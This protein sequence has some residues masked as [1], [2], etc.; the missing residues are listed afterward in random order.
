MARALLAALVVLMGAL[1]FRIHVPVVSL[2][3]EM[4]STTGARGEIFFASSEVG[5]TQDRSEPF[6]IHSDGE[7]HAYEVA[8]SPG[9]R[10]DRIRIDP[11]SGP[12]SVSVRAV[13]LSQGIHS[14]R[15]ERQRLVGAL[16]I[17]KH[18]QPLDPAALRFSSQGGDPYF[19]ILLP[20][21]MG[22]SSLLARAGELVAV[23]AIALATWILLEVLAAW[24]AKRIPPLGRIRPAVARVSDLL[25]DEQVLRVDG[26]IL[27]AFL[28]I[29]LLAAIYV[30]LRLHQSSIGIWETIHPHE[31]VEQTIDLGTPKRIRSDEWRVLTPWVLNQVLNDNPT[32]NRNLGGE[33]S[34]LAAAVPVDGVFAVPQ[35]K[36]A[37][38]RIFDLDRG[39]SWWWAYKSFGLV[40]SF[41]WL[42]LLLTRGN[43]AASLL[44]TLWIYFSSFTQWWFS[45]NTPE[46]MIAFAIGVVGAVY[47]LFS[48]KRGLIAMGG[49][50]MVYA[51]TNLVLHL[52]PPFIVPLA[53]LGV[54][55]L[56]GYWL[57]LGSTAPV[58]HR[59]GFRATTTAAAAAAISAYGLLF[60]S[61]ASDTID[62]MMNTVYPGQR[63]AE[64]GGVPLAKL[65]YGFF[66]SFRVGERHFPLQP[67]N[68]SEA[69]SFVLLFPIALLAMRWRTFWRREGALLLS[70]G[71]FCI[72]AACWISVSLP[73]PLERIMQ[74]LGWYLVPP[75]RPLIGLGIGSILACV[76]LF[77]QVQAR[78]EALHD[79]DVRSRSVVTVSV[80]LV[81]LGWGLHQVDPAFFS[82]RVILI[83]TVA[84]SLIAAGLMLGRTRLFAAGVLTYALSTAC[85][86]PLV[87]GISAISEKPILVAAAAQG[88]QPGDKWAVIGS[89]TFTQGL[90]AHGLD[91]IAGTHFLPDR[92]NIAILDPSGRYETIWNRYSTIEVVSDPSRTDV[93]FNKRRGDQISF[94]LNVCGRQ[95]RAL[96]VTHVAYTSAL[97]EEDLRCLKRLAGPADSGVQLFELRR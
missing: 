79:E 25:S 48:R 18:L 62:A 6:H 92:R 88:N 67:T 23:G 5:Y 74:A 35:L 19:E 76:V 38:F 53:Y 97:P 78:F 63:V 82:P 14:Q 71:C 68:A 11:G 12:G 90:K 42:C 70:L 61:A 57:Q 59:L 7:W 4:K 29:G 73:A 64:S 60:M 50:L 96:G 95:M 30:G 47:A 39:M 43:L 32:R 22:H 41:L 52:Y 93:E 2:A 3:L 85:V 34:P 91:V 58:L 8:F 27:L 69:S 54:A 13:A 49:V 37:G 31:T 75:R 17:T 1:L 15:F 36:F 16:G 56:A 26:R 86:N 24:L 21:S 89:V 84:A 40:F 66:E 81:M 33:S 51:A 46:I 72:V 9:I 45:A 10:I 77:S 28:C 94:T 83:G 87:S 80:A 44:G 20:D 65:M 55:I